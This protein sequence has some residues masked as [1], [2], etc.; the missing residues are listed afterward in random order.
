MKIITFQGGLGNQMFQYV[1]YQYLRSQYPEE[2]FYG[3][4]P[5]LALKDHNG[6]EI[7]LILRKHT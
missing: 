1:Y 5:K 6:L 2:T 7:N 4:Y 3:F